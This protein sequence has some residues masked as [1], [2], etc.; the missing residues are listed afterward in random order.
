MIDDVAVPP[1]PPSRVSTADMAAATVLL[2]LS[3]DSHGVSTIG[4]ESITSL[5]YDSGS[6]PQSVEYSCGGGYPAAGVGVHATIGNSYDATPHNAL[7]SAKPS[8]GAAF[9]AYRPVVQSG[10]PVWNHGLSAQQ[11]RLH[12]VQQVH[13]ADATTGRITVWSGSEIERRHVLE[14]RITVSMPQPEVLCPHVMPVVPSV[15]ALLTS[16]QMAAG[17]PLL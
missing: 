16:L 1:S 15:E 9:Q 17:W 13:Q 7:L 14:P 11:H 3:S 6:L 12:Q 4:D 8:A 10:A 2:S 5:R